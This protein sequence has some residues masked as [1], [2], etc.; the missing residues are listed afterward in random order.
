MIAEHLCTYADLRD[1]LTLDEVYDLNEVMIA[2]HENERR[3]H[4]AVKKRSKQA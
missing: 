2:R 1:R 4:E 3:A